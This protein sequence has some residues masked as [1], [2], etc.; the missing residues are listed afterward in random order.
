MSK[1]DEFVHFYTRN[2]RWTEK[3]PKPYSSELRLSFVCVCLIFFQFTTKQ[4]IYSS[5]WYI[6]LLTCM[7]NLNSM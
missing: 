3:K 7:K 6:V 1:S 5:T 4:Y 2:S